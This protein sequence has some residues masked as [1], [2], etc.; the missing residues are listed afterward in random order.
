MSRQ[1]CG[2][3]PIDTVCQKGIQIVKIDLKVH[4]PSHLTVSDHR[5]LV[6]YEGQPLTCYV[7]NE[8]GHLVN[9][10]PVRHSDQRGKD[11]LAMNRGQQRRLG[12]RV[13]RW[14]MEPT[15]YKH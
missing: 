10:C 5:A 4:I 11:M 6:S 9:P 3:R 7:Y 8:T 14:L 1:T 15:P 12:G 13:Q 2:R